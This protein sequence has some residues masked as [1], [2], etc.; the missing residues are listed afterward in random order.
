MASTTRVCLP[1][2]GVEKER[3]CG[4][5]L[6][7]FSLGATASARTTRETLWRAFL[8]LG[9]NLLRT[10]DPIERCRADQRFLRRK[11]SRLCFRTVNDA[12]R[13]LARQNG[14]LASA[15]APKLPH[16][17][18]CLAARRPTI[19]LL[20]GSGPWPAFFPEPRQ[21][22]RSVLG[23]WPARQGARRQV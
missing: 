16:S 3:R 15:I 1:Y 4:V 2:P 18:I 19:S 8:K 13:S 7:G 17:I 14:G 23:L 5:A 6:S 9:A 10:F 22:P 21:T 20:R 11:L 12:G